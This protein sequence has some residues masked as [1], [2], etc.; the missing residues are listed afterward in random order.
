MK[1]VYQFR[2]SEN[3]A[4]NSTVNCNCQKVFGFFSKIFQKKVNRRALLS[5]LTF[6]KFSERYFVSTEA[7]VLMKSK[8]K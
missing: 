4:K 5:F 3:V 6:F 1:N 8:N 7:S 2:L